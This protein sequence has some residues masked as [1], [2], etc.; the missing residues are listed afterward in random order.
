MHRYNKT[1]KIMKKER[2]NKNNMAQIDT[3]IKSSEKV[4]ASGMKV[5]IS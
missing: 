5:T 3:Y 1:V 4:E 2:R